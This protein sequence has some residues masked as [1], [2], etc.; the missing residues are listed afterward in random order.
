MFRTPKW[1]LRPIEALYRAFSGREDLIVARD[2][3]SCAGSRCV[4]AERKES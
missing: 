1:I 3:A 2:I 4:G